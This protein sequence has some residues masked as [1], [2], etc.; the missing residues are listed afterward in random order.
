MGVS[1]SAGVL[2]EAGVG[3]GA[4]VALGG[5]DGVAVGEGAEAERVQALSKKDA[6]EKAQIKKRSGLR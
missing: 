6:A 5:G 1:L 2:L 3:M 4:R